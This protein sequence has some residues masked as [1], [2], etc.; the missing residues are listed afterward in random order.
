MNFGKAHGGGNRTLLLSFI[1]PGIVVVLVFALTIKLLRK[2]PPRTVCISTGPEG[3]DLVGRRL[4][5]GPGN[6]RQ[7]AGALATTPTDGG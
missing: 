3:G 4:M 6:S 1:G 7:R 2:G 5:Q